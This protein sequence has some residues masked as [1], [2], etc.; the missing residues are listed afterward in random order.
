MYIY[1]YIYIICINKYI[2]MYIYMYI[3]THICISIYLQ[4]Y[5]SSKYYCDDSIQ[6]SF[7]N[8][9]SMAPPVVC[10]TSK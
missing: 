6:N 3:Y 7:L 9:L 2:Y 10:P 8:S 5:T 4:I 1:V